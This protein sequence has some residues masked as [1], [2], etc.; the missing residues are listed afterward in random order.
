MKKQI[1]KKKMYTGLGILQLFISIAAIPAGLGFILDPSGGN[2][3]MTTEL[4]QNSPFG[5]YFIPG[6]ILFTVNGIGSLFGSFVSFYKH[7][8]AG[9]LSMV[10]GLALIIWIIAQVYWMGLVSWLQPFIFVLGAI[11]LILAINLTNNQRDLAEN[12]KVNI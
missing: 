5:S 9:V 11:E 6:I 12:K 1:R 8:S 3:A 7:K 2:L 10:L 4:I